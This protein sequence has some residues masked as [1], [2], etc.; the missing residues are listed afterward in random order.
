[1]TTQRGGI[2]HRQEPEGACAA[3]QPKARG[4]K[5]PLTVALIG[6]HALGAFVYMAIGATFIGW[7][8]CDIPGADGGA[9]IAAGIAFL[10]VLAVVLLA[11][12]VCLGRAVYV[13]GKYH[14]W[15]I[16][17]YALAV[18]FLWALAV[19]ILRCPR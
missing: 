19:F 15:P 1:M 12:L 14:R 18:P 3:F 10:P 11:S 6:V 8:T 17:R 9:D 16:S 4:G 5:T 13:Y 7:E 2:E